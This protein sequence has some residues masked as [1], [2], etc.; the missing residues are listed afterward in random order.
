[1]R[2]LIIARRA[3]FLALAASGCGGGSG[4]QPTMCFGSNVVARESNNYKFSST[5]LVPPVKVAQMANLR[6]D[7]SGLSKDFLGRSLNPTTD[8]G[9]ALVMIWNLPR[10]EFEKNLNADAL[11]TADLV[12]SPP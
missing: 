8:L 7:W 10:A 12:V 11:F 4:P 5:I 3:A 2:V 1:M 6:F 9:M